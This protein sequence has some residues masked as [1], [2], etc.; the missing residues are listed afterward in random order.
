MPP[1]LAPSGTVGRRSISQRTY[2][3]LDR[4]A[5]PRRIIVCD[6]DAPDLRRPTQV[7]GV[8]F[9]GYSATR[10]ESECRGIYELQ[11]DRLRVCMPPPGADFPTVFDPTAGLLL[12]LHHD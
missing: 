3:R 9:G 11:G 5:S 12:D 4:G 10:P 7:L 1:T 6:A 8:S 2:F